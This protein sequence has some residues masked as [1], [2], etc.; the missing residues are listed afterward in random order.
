MPPTRPLP[1]PWHLIPVGVAALALHGVAA[2]HYLAVRL[3]VGP[4]LDLLPEQHAD[5]IAAL[6]L[7]VA[8]AWAVGVWAGV[9]G[10]I[11]LLLREDGAAI[12]FAVAFLGLAA[13]TVHLVLFAAPPLAAALGPDALPLLGGSCLLV[14]LFWLYARAQKVAGILT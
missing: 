12:A 7:W 5:L 14:L 1:R 9:L 8:V 3:G 11:L 6:P 13:A 4:A 2:A 10:A